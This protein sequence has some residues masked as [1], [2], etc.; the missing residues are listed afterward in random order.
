MAILEN[1]GTSPRKRK[2]VAK[3]T[4]TWDSLARKAGTSPAAV[5]SS[6]PNIVKLSAGNTVTLPPPEKTM[7]QAQ[8]PAPATPV[9]NQ[10]AAGRMST[11]PVSNQQSRGNMTYMGSSQGSR[12]IPFSEMGS[13]PVGQLPGEVARTARNILPQVPGMVAGAVVGGAATG[14][15]SAIQAAK[16]GIANAQQGVRNFAAESAWRAGRA[17]QA[18]AQLPSTPVNQ[19]GQVMGQALFPRS[20]QTGQRP[21]AQAGVSARPPSAAQVSAQGQYGI[22]PGGGPTNGQEQPVYAASTLDVYNKLGAGV[23]IQNGMVNYEVIPPKI[24]FADVAGLASAYG[25]TEDELY[26]HLTTVGYLYDPVTGGYYLPSSLG[27]GGTG[28]TGGGGGYGGYYGGG[29]GGGSGSGTDAWTYSSVPIRWNIKP[30][31]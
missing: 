21:Q 28:G 30:G 10:A 7:D 3:R 9:S 5:R 11:A 29:G 25:M 13:V 23:D 24:N 4:D 26:A 12:V 6:N 14:V 16:Q 1:K 22:G 20:A 18:V 2:V 31:A 8:R 27:G 15:P 17:G 19:V